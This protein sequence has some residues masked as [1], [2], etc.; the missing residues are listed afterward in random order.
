SHRWKSPRQTMMVDNRGS[1]GGVVD[2]L[3]S[4]ADVMIAHAIVVA[5]LVVK[6]AIKGVVKRQRIRFSI[7]PT[8]HRHRHRQTAMR[9]NQITKKKTGAVRSGCCQVVAKTRRAVLITA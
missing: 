1:A 3:D 4:R 5:V 2:I 9:Q 7:N 8:N 6:D